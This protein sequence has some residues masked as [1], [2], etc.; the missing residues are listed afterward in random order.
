MK[1]GIFG[2]SKINNKKIVKIAQEIGIIL[3]SYKHTVV[4]GGSEGYPHIVA[5]SAIKAGGKAIAYATGMLLSDHS[6]F[7]KTDLSKYS[8]IVFQKKYFNKQLLVIDN[9]FR[10]LEMCLNIDFA[11]IIGG[12]TGT[13]YE[14]TIMSGMSKDILVLKGSGGVTGQTIKKFINEG[15]KEKSKIEY[16]N[17][18]RQFKKYL[19][20]IK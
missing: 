19:N 17:N 7:H 16:F 18:L 20:N 15:H 10:S 3:A 5:L 12:R 8:K 11:I 13:M 6:K 14:V 1:I 9:Y 2:G 4:T